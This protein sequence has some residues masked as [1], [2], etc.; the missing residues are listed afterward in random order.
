MRLSCSRLNS[1]RPS[2]SAT[3]FSYSSVTALFS[4][5]SSLRVPSL[6]FAPSIWHSTLLCWGEA[7]SIINFAELAYFEMCPYVS[8]H[9]TYIYTAPR[10]LGHTYMRQTGVA[11]TSKDDQPLSF[12][13]VRCR[14]VAARAGSVHFNGPEGRG[15]DQPTTGSPQTIQH[16]LVNTKRHTMMFHHNP[17][18]AW[19][20]QAHLHAINNTDSLSSSQTTIPP[21]LVNWLVNRGAWQKVKGHTERGYTHSRHINRAHDEYSSRKPGL[22]WASIN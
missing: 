2:F 9:I 20:E 21:G 16:S 18:P 17:L 8:A 12:Y 19:V 10:V 15:Q 1:F 6:S 7:F 22:T 5:T 4:H 3:R 11:L 14:S 13:H